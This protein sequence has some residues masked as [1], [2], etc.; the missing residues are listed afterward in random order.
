MKPSDPNLQNVP[1]RS[2]L[3]DEIRKAFIGYA[4]L[5]SSDYTQIELRLLADLQ[6]EF[7]KEKKR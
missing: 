6:R 5:I 2:D 3:S 1:I 7:G 4:P